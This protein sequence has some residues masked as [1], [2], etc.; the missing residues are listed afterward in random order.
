RDLVAEIARRPPAQ[1]PDHIVLDGSVGGTGAAPAA[2]AGN[3]GTPIRES[4][5]WFDNLL[6]EHQVRDRLRLIAAGRFATAAEVAFGLALGAD[7]INIARGFLLSMGCIQAMQCHT[8]RCPTGITTHSK[9]LQ[10][11]LDPADKGVRV[12]NYAKAIRKELMII[13]RSLGLKSPSEINRTH[14]C[15]TTPD[16]KSISLADLW[17]YP[18]GTAPQGPSRTKSGP[19]AQGEIAPT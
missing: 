8:N 5:P 6:R 7:T 18:P 16:G 2:L 15:L 12:A 11:G 19:G 10:A 9:W 17:P 13:T 4:L 3:M 1:S 14:V